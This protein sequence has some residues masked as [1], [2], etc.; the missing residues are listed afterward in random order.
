MKM[1]FLYKLGGGKNQPLKSKTIL[2]AAMAAAT[3]TLAACTDED[4]NIAS[5]STPLQVQTT[6]NQARSVITDTAFGDGQSIGITLVD[7]TDGATAYEGKTEGYTNVPYTSSGT[8]ESQ[9]WSAQNPI[10]L[11]PTVGKAVAYYPYAQANADYKAIPVTA[12]GQTD[13]MYSGWTDADGIS[14]ADAKATFVMQHALSAIRITVK[15]GSYSQ[16]GSLSA[17]SLTSDGFGVSGTLN[18]A[19]GALAGVAAAEVNSTMN[20]DFVTANITAEGLSN[21]LMVA[22]T[23]IAEAKPMIVTVT[24][25]GKQYAAQANMTEPVVQGKIYSVALLLDNKTFEVTEVDITPWN[26]KQPVD[27]GTLEAYDPYSSMTAIFEVDDV[28][29]PT[30]LLGEW[31]PIAQMHSMVIDGQEV[32]PTRTYTFPEP[33]NYTVRY[34][35]EPGKLTNASCMFEACTKL[36]YINVAKCAKEIIKNMGGMF[37]NCTILETIDLSPLNT[38]KVT[39]MAQLFRE[40]NNLKWIDMTGWNT[41]N[42]TNM[43]RMFEGCK[44]LAN[45]EVGNFNTA[46][47]TSMAWMFKDCRILE[48]LDVSNFNTAN[49]T[50]MQSMFS[51]CY[52]L[53]ELDVSSFD[54]S[55]V[56]NMQSMF[57]SCKNL[58]SLNMSS[59]NTSNVTKMDWMFYECENMKRLDLKHFNTANVTDMSAMFRWCRRMEGL[60]LSGWDVSK[61]TS[62]YS[63]F[64]EC[65]YL[66]E[67]DLL[68]F[69][70]TSAKNFNEMFRLCD[71]LKTLNI[72]NFVTDNV[73]NM[74]YMFGG[75]LNLTELDVRHFKTS[76][77]TDM[78]Y[79]FGGLWNV[80]ELDLTGFDTSNVTNMEGMLEGLWKVEKIDVSSFNTSN[81]TNMKWM[82]SDNKYLEELDISNLD[83]SNVLNM[84]GMFSACYALKSIDLSNK[85]L[86]KVTN[87][88]TMF[89][90]RS[91]DARRNPLTIT[92]NGS[93]NPTADCTDMFTSTLANGTPVGYSLTVN[94]PADKATE[95]A[96]IIEAIPE[97]GTANPI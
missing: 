86:E 34:Q 31:F 81:V 2:F 15:K 23:G 6:L 64:C 60:D 66:E 44:S 8:G 12:Q 84:E 18:A 37:L 25:D 83:T 87:M 92:F 41:S 75:C 59:F 53:K 51:G 50:N 33:G 57:S 24:I 39:H 76:N 47:V 20:P 16:T 95:C 73:T 52:K 97:W 43:E 72:N 14:N 17:I 10:M 26:E 70:T 1:N 9:I 48:K 85:N 69:V 80:K 28:S 55:K 94:Y 19:T 74:G 65:H 62:F 71:K 96:A 3:I 36:K 45:L 11:S 82:F 90:R 13:Y 4:D 78:S 58:T 32:Q 29:I 35:F 40:C 7:N 68:S 42:V 63:M 89:S 49:V 93:V 21:I 67:L 79:M 56:T 77:V 22:P 88:K 91:W 54:T 61:V 27:G 38:S 30:R 5:Q 46:K